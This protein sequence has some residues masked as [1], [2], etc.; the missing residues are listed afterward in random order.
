VRGGRS[1]SSCQ[2]R[3]SRGP[4]HRRGASASPYDDFDEV[5]RAARAGADD[6]WARIYRD[7]APPLL[8]YLR[9]QG[10]PDPENLLGEVMLQ[11]VRSVEKFSGGE[12]GFRSWVFTIAHNRLVDVR[13][14]R[15][16]R[17]ED[18]APT[19]DLEPVMPAT[20]S[21]PE[22]MAALTTEEVVGLLDHLTDDQ[23][24]VLL[25][26]LVG[27]LQLAEI[28][29]VTGRPRQAVKSLQKRGIE[30]LRR[31]IGVRPADTGNPQSGQP[32]HDGPPRR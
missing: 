11:V 4:S 8:G 23:R 7:L 28:V 30:Q 18:L 10:A 31:L 16:R 26:R 19:E 2:P 5:L 20:T 29:E 27:G 12:D 1:R 22:A 6:A 21:E 32:P 14:S 17:P 15:G 3:P 9:G 13:R 24:E 25:L